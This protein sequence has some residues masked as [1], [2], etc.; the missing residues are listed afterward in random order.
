MENIENV[1]LFI[2]SLDSSISSYEN[3]LTPL[4]KTNLDDLINTAK[5]GEDKIQILNNFAYVFISTIYSYL[6]SIGIDTDSHPIKN[7]LNRVKTY[8]ARYKNYING[9][10]NEEQRQEENQQKTKEFLTNTLGIKN[11]ES[12]TTTERHSGPAISSESFKGK[13]TRFKDESESEDDVTGD[14]KKDSIIESEGFKLPKKSKR[15][16]KQL[17]NKS[18]KSISSL[19]KSKKNDGNIVNSDKSKIIKP[20]KNKSKDSNSK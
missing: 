6:K 9:V 2:R 4:L 19:N 15:K 1:K 10:K 16:M 7:E 20:K 17:P 14:F 5:T 12:L 8:M 3:S 18:T 13:H 11:V